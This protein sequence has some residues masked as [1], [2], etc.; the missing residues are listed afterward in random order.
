M[1]SEERLKQ[2][3]PGTGLTLEELIN[4]FI[5]D[6]REA[7]KLKVYLTRNKAEEGE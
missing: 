4:A 3:D 5:I 1:S 2:I 7:K 6:P